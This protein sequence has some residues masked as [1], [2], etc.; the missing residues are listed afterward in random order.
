[1]STTDDIDIANAVT[2]GTST[3][4]P[5]AGMRVDDPIRIDNMVAA[6][7]QT[8][9][10]A[11]GRLV[12]R[13][14]PVLDGPQRVTGTIGFTSNLTVPGMTVARV[15]RSPVPHAR[16]LD[17]D[18]SAAQEIAGVVTILTGAD[19]DLPGA[20][21]SHFGEIPN[22]PIVCRDRVMFVGDVVAA[23]VAETEDAAQAAVEAIRV[24]YELLPVVDSIDDAMAVDS[25]VLHEP[26]PTVRA[27]DAL[28]TKNVCGVFVLRDGDVK[29]GFEQSDHIFEGVYETPLV[30]H[31]CLETHTALA[32]FEA[33]GSLTITAATQTAHPVRA[34]LAYLFGLPLASVRVL[35][36]PIG[37]SFG[38]K[39]YPKIEPL[40][41]ALAWKARRPVKLVLQREESAIT[42]AKHASRI[43][44]R[45]GVMRDG[46]IVA[47]QVRAVFDAGAYAD[48]SHRFIVP[49]GYSCIGPY[50]TPN[51]DIDS[52]AV[53]T[54]H[55]STG[56]YRGFGVGEAA[57]AYEQQ[58]DEIADCLGLDPVEVRRRNLMHEGDRFPTGEYMREA[59]WDELLQRSARAIDYEHNRRVVVDERT[60]RAKGVGVIAKAT[61]T[62]STTQVTVNFNADGTLEVFTSASD[63]GQGVH[64]VI[65]QIAAEQLGIPITAVR[66][67]TPDT[68]MSPYDEGTH[69]S[70]S[71]RA[72]GVA[73]VRAVEDVRA[74]L[75]QLAGLAMG[76]GDV[77]VGEGGVEVVGDPQS[78]IPFAEVMR[79]T[80]VGTVVGHG[81]IITQGGHHPETG[82]G[83]ASDHWHQGAA[84]AEI[85]V[86]LGTG[87][88][89]VTHLH[90]ITYAGRVINPAMAKGQLHGSAVLALSHTLYEKLHYDA[91]IPLNTSLGEYTLASLVDL[92][93]RLEVELMEEEGV[94]PV[95]GLGEQTLPPIIAA[96]GNAVRE[97]IGRPVTRLPITPERV[98][99]AVEMAGR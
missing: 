69:S 7:E 8:V 10:F 25:P 78:R 53:Y 49:A 15:L 85:E 70:R 27:D 68:R 11:P 55:V 80:L 26:G 33:D 75:V 77:I 37:G 35:V 19:F 39:T 32:V 92:P 83:V 88:V 2:A 47:R 46:R 3:A 64:T 61:I 13:Q 17:V 57:W 6:N 36:P 96:I 29:D 74:Q 18:T 56:S 79:R 59:H 87:K 71:T 42:S 44:M 98:L 89:R 41:A 23:V 58:M 93:E 20:P 99:E 60:I 43:W 28:G 22:Q 5:D 86:D 12:G 54:N 52:R 9:L 21:H 73:T 38:A 62:P 97:A 90:S 24:E 1:M 72:Q 40:V 31:V 16:I 14:V 81:T 50:R 4:V 76:T 34:T 94:A 48:I 67:C 30:Q 91:G 82:R 63:M 66:V 95:H 65:A 45:T 51:V 84:G